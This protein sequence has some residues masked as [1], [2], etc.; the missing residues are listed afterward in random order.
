METKITC[1]HCMSKNCF[2]EEQVE[3][4]SYMCFSCGFMS[5]S[6]FKEKSLEIADYMKNMPEL[7]RDLQFLDTTRDLVWFPSIL[8]MGDKGMIY[9]ESTKH[10]TSKYVW[11]YAK[12]VD[13]PSESK[14]NYDGHKKFLDV[15]N[16]KEYGMFEFMDACIEM[17]IIKQDLFE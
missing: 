12:V 2:V 10:E 9:P 7:V 17:G 16:A 4:S 1:P 14:E 11:R 8:N 5:D 15:E 3:F 6:R 13:V